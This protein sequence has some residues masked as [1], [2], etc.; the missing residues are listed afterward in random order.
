M[1]NNCSLLVRSK[2]IGVLMVQALQAQ[3]ASNIKGRHALYNFC[4]SSYIFV[5]EVRI[6]QFFDAFLKHHLHVWRDFCAAR[7]R[8]CALL[9]NNSTSMGARSVKKSIRGSVNFIRKNDSGTGHASPGRY[10][11]RGSACKQKVKRASIRSTS[12]QERCSAKILMAAAGAGRFFG[13]VGAGYAGSALYNHQDQLS[14]VARSVAQA[15]N[16]PDSCVACKVAAFR[17]ISSPTV[18]KAAEGG[19]CLRQGPQ[20]KKKPNSQRLH[21]RLHWELF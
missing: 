20:F 16:L 2:A 14:G 1:P 7:K 8:L 11:Q 13:L 19:L 9:V 10:E 4:I 3:S 18:T 21:K 12:S 17:Q 15:R 5:G 6:L